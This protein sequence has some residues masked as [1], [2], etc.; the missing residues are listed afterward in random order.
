MVYSQNFFKTKSK[1]VKTFAVIHVID[2]NIMFAHFFIIFKSKMF[3]KYTS[4]LDQYLEKY[5]EISL[6]L[7]Y[8]IEII[9]I[10]NY[11]G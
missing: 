4:D 6:K 5:F 3:A 11:F 2:K 10:K 9:A 8:Q 7:K 1:F